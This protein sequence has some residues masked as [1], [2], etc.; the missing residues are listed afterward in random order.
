[1]AQH[2][3]NQIYIPGFIVQVSRIGTSQFMRA[4][5]RFQRC[6]HGGIFFDQVLDGT[7]CNPLALEAQEQRVLMSGQ[8]FH[9]FPLFHIIRQ[10]V[11]NFGGEIQHDLV[12]AFPGHDKSVVFEIHIRKVH[13][14]AFADT[15]SGA[16]KQG[17]QGKITFCR[18]F[19]IFLLSFGHLFS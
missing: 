1:M 19:L 18:D 6:R 12:A 15:D 16:E 17:K 5:F 7:L 8:R 4:D 10:G 2:V 13:P 14:D 9:V 3:S 11:G